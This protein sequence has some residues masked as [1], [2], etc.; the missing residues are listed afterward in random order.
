ML[1]NDNHENWFWVAGIY[2]TPGI[3]NSTTS[4]IVDE[5]NEFLPTE[6]KLYQNYPNPFNPVTTINMQFRS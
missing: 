5:R 1:D 3:I 4:Y 2:G 6:F